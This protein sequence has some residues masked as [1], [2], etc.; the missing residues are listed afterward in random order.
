MKLHPIRYR[1][2]DDNAMGIRDRDEHVGFVAQDVQRVIPEAVTENNKGYLLVNNDPILWT[3]L[4][5][6][7]EQQDEI[8]ALRAQLRMRSAST[9]KPVA[10]ETVSD[11]ADDR[12]L[13]TLRRQLMQLR[14]KDGRLEARLARLEHAL[15]R[16]NSTNTLAL[17]SST[18]TPEEK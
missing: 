7:K 8:V 2:K 3:M 18:T 16:L 15:D 1:Y 17:A 11:R 12:E 10:I 13:R 14:N 4:N 5:A 9:T 6:I